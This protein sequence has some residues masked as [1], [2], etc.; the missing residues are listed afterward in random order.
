METNGLIMS[1]VLGVLVVGW[2]IFLFRFTSKMKV[3]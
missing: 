2:G 3:D 1:A